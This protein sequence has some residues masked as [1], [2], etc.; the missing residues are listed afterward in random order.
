NELRARYDRLPPERRP[1]DF[2][3]ALEHHARCHLIH[4]LLS[5]LNWRLD[6]TLEDGLP[7]LFCEVAVRS[8][9][10]GT[11]RLLDYLGIQHETNDPLLI[12]EAKRP[13]SSLPYLT[14]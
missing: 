12:V 7:N 6:L 10:L 11:R 5:G 8:T 4:A 13:S 9:T 1:R 2:D 14:S 3:E